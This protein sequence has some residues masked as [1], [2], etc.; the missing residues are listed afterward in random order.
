LGST[1][2]YSSPPPQPPP[3]RSLPIHGLPERPGGQLQT[4]RDSPRRE[5][6]RGGREK[7]VREAH[8]Q[9]ERERE[10]KP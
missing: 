10:R 8:T 9:R 3:P 1:A 7:R 5:G 6:S 4:E 2:G